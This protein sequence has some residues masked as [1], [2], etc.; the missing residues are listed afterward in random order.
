LHK[1]AAYGGALSVGFADSSP[2]GGAKKLNHPKSWLSLW[3]SWHAAGVTE[4]APEGRSPQA[5]LD[6]LSQQD[7]N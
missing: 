5:T 1:I 6:I 3:E 4:R 7:Y 2:R